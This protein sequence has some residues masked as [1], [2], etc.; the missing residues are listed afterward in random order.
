MTWTVVMRSV[1]RFRLFLLALKC[2]KTILTQH[3]KRSDDVVKCML[4]CSVMEALRKKH[5]EELEREVEKVK[6]LS[7]GVV[8]SQTLQ[9]QQQ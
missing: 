1:I 8:D 3:L 6:R 2:F 7:S 5:K 4:C 9:V